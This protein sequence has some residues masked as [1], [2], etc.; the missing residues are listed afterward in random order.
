MVGLGCRRQS[1]NHG[2]TGAAVSPHQRGSHEI[3]SPGHSIAPSHSITEPRR[4]QGKQR[5]HQ[6]RPSNSTRD[7][8]RRPP[9][10]TEPNANRRHRCGSCQTCGGV[11]IFT[12]SSAGDQRRLETCHWTKASTA[13]AAC[14]ENAVSGSVSDSRLAFGRMTF[15]NYSSLSFNDECRMQND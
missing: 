11:T 3:C 14:D 7:R 8:P 4:P 12:G 13:C 10:L 9:A 15:H 6:D 1:A 5:A 2:A